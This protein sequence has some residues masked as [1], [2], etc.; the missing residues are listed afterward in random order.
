MDGLFHLLRG[1]EPAEAQ[2]YGA[3]GLGRG[4][5]QR[6][7]Y[8]GRRGGSGGASAAAACVEF[9][10]GELLQEGLGV[11][12]VEPQV[13]GVRQARF[14]AAVAVR[15]W[16]IFQDALLQLVAQLFYH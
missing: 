1:G 16:D 14:T 12:L 2:S 10:V 11:D 3:A 15:A 5:A 9:L 7:Q 8:V 6:Q 13:G 4:E